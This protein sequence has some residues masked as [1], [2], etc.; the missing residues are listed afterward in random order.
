M[1][2]KKV[3]KI[4]LS[5]K[6]LDSSKNNAVAVLYVTAWSIFALVWR[7][8]GLAVLDVEVNRINIARSEGTRIE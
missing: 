1:S 3:I 8:C 7:R 2:A 4:I 5:R 6:S